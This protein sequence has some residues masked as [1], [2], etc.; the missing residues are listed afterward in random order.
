MKTNFRPASHENGKEISPP[1][2]SIVIS[3]TG[4][5]KSTANDPLKYVSAN[6]GLIHTK[7]DDAME[8]TY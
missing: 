4:A 8:L 7:L 6:L 5:Y 2:I 1:V 3:G